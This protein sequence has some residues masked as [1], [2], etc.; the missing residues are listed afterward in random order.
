VRVEAVKALSGSRRPA[1]G[2]VPALIGKLSDP[3]PVVR[4]EAAHSLGTMGAAA[5]EARAAL[6]ALASDTNQGVRLAGLDAAEK[7]NRPA[8]SNAARGN[9]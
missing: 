1:K 8:G 2:T 3:V 5:S 6:Q 4:E 7:V 9:Q